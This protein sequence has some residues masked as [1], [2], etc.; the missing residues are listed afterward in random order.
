MSDG[1][2]Y[3]YYPIEKLGKYSLWGSFLCSVLSANEGEAPVPLPP[4]LEGVHK[5]RFLGAPHLLRIVA[6]HAVMPRA[7]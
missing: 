7:I 5:Y 4:F 2:K 3:K 1:L 6:S